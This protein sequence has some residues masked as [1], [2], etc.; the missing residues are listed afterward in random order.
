MD[1]HIYAVK[2]LKT[3]PENIFNNMNRPLY[4]LLLFMLENRTKINHPNLYALGY[5]SIRSKR[6]SFKLLDM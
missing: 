3:V 2:L 6:S 4:H 1:I 5:I